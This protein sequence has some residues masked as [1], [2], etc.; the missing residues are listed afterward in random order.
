[1]RKYLVS[2]NDLPPGGKEFT[3]DDQEIWLGPLKEFHMDC[4]IE[5]PLAARINV[6]PTEDGCLVRGRLTGGVV[7][8]CNRCAE[9]AAVDIDAAIEEFE[10][11]PAE[12]N[13]AS[14]EA[15][16]DGASHVVYDRH[17]P[18]LDLAAVC[19]EEFMLALPVAPLCREDC[20]GLC[21]RCGTNLNEGQCGCTPDEG[22]HRMAPLRDLAAKRQ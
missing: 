16:P 17:A 21:P 8:P 9:D 2:I 18:M 3:L 19:W 4:R 13:A 7:V 20:K 1:M 10:E 14:A 6:V 5:R 12:E 11:I 15:A 22:D